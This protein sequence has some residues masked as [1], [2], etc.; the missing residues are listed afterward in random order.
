MPI[1]I[2]GGRIDGN[3]PSFQTEVRK[4]V[5]A[6]CTVTGPTAAATDV[7]RAPFA[8][9]MADAA[10]PGLYVDTG[11][12]LPVVMP[13]GALR[14]TWYAEGGTVA[15]ADSGWF[16]KGTNRFIH[17]SST[18]G[19][20]DAAW[21]KTLITAV[22]APENTMRQNFTTDAGIGS[23]QQTVIGSDATLVS[24][25]RTM[26]KIPPGVTVFV[27]LRSNGTSRGTWSFVTPNTVV[28]NSTPLVGS[29]FSVVALGDDTYLINATGIA[30]GTGEINW[31]FE[32][33]SSAAFTG[34]W[35][36]AGEQ[37]AAAFTGAVRSGAAQVLTPVAPDAVWAPLARL[38]YLTS[39][40]VECT[41][42]VEYGGWETKAG[43]RVQFRTAL[44][45][46][47]EMSQAV[48]SGDGVLLRVGESA[49]VDPLLIDLHLRGAHTQF[50]TAVAAQS[51]FAFFNPTTGA[52][53]SHYVAAVSGV[54][55]NRIASVVVFPPGGAT[56]VLLKGSVGAVGMSTATAS[57]LLAN[58][59]GG[60]V[61]LVGGD[62]VHTF[63]TGAN[64]VNDQ[65]IVARALVVAGGG[66][67][68][69]A[70]A[71]GGGAG[72]YL[73]EAAVVIP[74]GLN[75]VTV[76]TGGAGGTGGNNGVNGTNSVLST[77]TA[78]GGGFGASTTNNGGGGGSGGG[79]RTGTSSGAGTMGQGSAGG[80]DNPA[81]NGTSGGG[82]GASAAGGTASGTVC[83]AGGDGLS[84]DIRTGSALFY[85]GGGGGGGYQQGPTTGGAG[86]NGGGGAGA[87]SA[88]GTAGT[89]NTGGG[90]GGG[91]YSN[92]TPTNYA[93][94]AGGSGIVVVRYS[95]AQA[96]RAGRISAID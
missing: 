68:G 89:V 1:H 43:P 20:A 14:A 2:S 72:G 56:E 54:A 3:D 9:V 4:S 19:I 40:E 94:G 38:P 71:G 58:V 22:S 41:G 90:G 10:I 76:G 91:G 39:C 80:F 33:L 12:L 31:K 87:A 65:D 24:S 69:S 7:N 6:T 46:A 26:Q 11:S 52:A 49:G 66:G 84:S 55:P 86:G 8:D 88:A 53:I 15:L 37:Q 32:Y 60:T 73:N 70:I 21:V 64:F 16:E 83:G 5:G 27:S 50:P 82:G 79:V 25:M 36:G 18:T 45:V 42:R 35:I 78:I 57:G 96:A 61:S 93:G 77:L 28:T 85:A 67:G 47:I 48:T 75:P 62:R 63:L 29:T 13:L 81:V 92:V 74:L 59:V 30:G 51:D 23:I 17:G 95:L 34:Q 44:S